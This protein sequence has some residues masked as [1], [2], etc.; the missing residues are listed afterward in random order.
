MAQHEIRRINKTIS[1]LQESAAYYHFDGRIVLPD[2]AAQAEFIA[3]EL[4][5]AHKRLRELL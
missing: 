3:A 5:K 2:D 1:R 4:V